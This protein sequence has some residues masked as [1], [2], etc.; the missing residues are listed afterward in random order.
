M[1]ICEN[2]QF[3]V[4]SEEKIYLSWIVCVTVLRV[5]VELVERLFPKILPFSV[6]G[7]LTSFN[8]IFLVITVNCRWKDEGRPKFRHKVRSSL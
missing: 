1:R 2:A 6:L 5:Y 3:D 8:Q 7:F 4:L